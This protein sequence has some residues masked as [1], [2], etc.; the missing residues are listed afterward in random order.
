MTTPPSV[1]PY[2]ATLVDEE[3]AVY[4]DEIAQRKPFS[5]LKVCIDA[6]V[7]IA[8][9]GG[10]FAWT[11]VGFLMLTSLFTSPGMSSSAMLGSLFFGSMLYFGIGAV[12]ALLAAIPVVTLSGWL[13]SMPRRPRALDSSQYSRVRQRDRSA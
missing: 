11:I 2:A 6:T 7:M 3:V 5:S 1:N 12:L 9:S 4:E 8:V 13:L 10:L